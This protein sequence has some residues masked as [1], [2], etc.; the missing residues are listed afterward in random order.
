MGAS[1]SWNPQGQSKPVMGL[2]Q[3]CFRV[4]FTE[5]RVLLVGAECPVLE[6]NA[7]RLVV[8]GLSEVQ[9]FVYATAWC[10]SEE[11]T[12]TCGYFISKQLCLTEY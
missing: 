3:L 1:T 7:F 4:Q 11:E 8:Q 6:V 9:M 10:W 2:L 5:V 12:E